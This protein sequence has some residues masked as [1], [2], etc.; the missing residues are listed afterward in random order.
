MNS[1]VW[2]I[3]LPYFSPVMDSI[4]SL[5]LSF[6]SVNLRSA[7]KFLSSQSMESPQRPK[8]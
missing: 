8:L 2:L 1:A 6:L 7:V 3:I 4:A 5:V